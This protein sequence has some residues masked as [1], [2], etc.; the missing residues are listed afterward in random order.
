[1]EFVG[2]FTFY[3]ILV[4]VSPSYLY[5][6]KSG[7]VKGPGPRERG[8][9]MF[10]SVAARFDSTVFPMSTIRLRIFLFVGSESVVEDLNFS[11]EMRFWSGGRVYVGK[12]IFTTTCISNA[13]TTR[14]RARGLGQGQGKRTH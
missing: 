12:F 10:K 11:C 5:Q 4:C 7:E 14:T 2:G 9:Y 1:M 8:R 3:S 13:Y 6:G